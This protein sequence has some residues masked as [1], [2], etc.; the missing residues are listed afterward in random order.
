MI[1]S[2]S[3]RAV[4]GRFASG[5]TVVTARAADGHDQGMT[6]TS[7]C[8]LSLEPPLILVC[9]A[10]DALMHD[11]LI[12]VDHFA[13]SIL[14]ATQ[15]PLSRRF[16]DPDPDRFEGIGFTRGRTG[17]PLLDDALAHLECRRVASHPGGDHTIVV[18]EVLDATIRQDRPLL[19]YR[20][21]YAQL[22]R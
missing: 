6:V 15:E 1:D 14:S 8:S 2:D 16:S 12:A 18:G 4:L 5:V 9:I 10:H 22:E 21:G 19:Y 20:S 13:V 3:F 7:F 11:N 17:A